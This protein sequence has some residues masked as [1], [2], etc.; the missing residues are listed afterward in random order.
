MN[1]FDERYRAPQSENTGLRGQGTPELWNPNAAACW[2]LLFSPIFGAALHMLNARAL[3]DQELEK[4]NKA[5]IWGMLAVVAIAIPI[6]VIFDI[7]TNV[8]GLALLGAWYGGVGRKQVAQVKDEFG[9]DYPRKSWGKPIFFGILGVC[10]LFVYS[11][12]VI[13]VLSMMGM[14]SL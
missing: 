12:I 3:G 13:F 2:S 14:V 6:F 10:G 11:F 9:T 5:F 4:L 1:N 7:G 8:L